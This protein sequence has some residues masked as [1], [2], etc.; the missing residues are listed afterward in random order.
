MCMQGDLVWHCTHT[1]Q[2]N[3]VR[4]GVRSMNVFGDILSI[5]CTNG[6]LSFYDVVASKYMPLENA[7][8][9]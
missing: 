7:K 9:S 6:T 8:V 2:A 4:A 1:L 3:D 5:G